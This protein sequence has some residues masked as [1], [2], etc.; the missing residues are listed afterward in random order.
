MELQKSEE[1]TKLLESRNIRDEDLIEVIQHAEGKGEKFH[2]RESARY[3]AK[4][5]LSEATYY[6]VYTIE[7]GRYV[8]NSAYWH[9]SEIR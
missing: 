5:R 1:V 7:E 8:I 2:H 3:I 6:V 9:K 4:K